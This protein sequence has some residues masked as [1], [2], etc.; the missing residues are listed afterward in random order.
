M[1]RRGRG[2]GSARE[3]GVALVE[4]ALLVPI[5]ALLSM[6][7]YEFS[8]AWQSN[9]TVQSSIRAAARTGSGLGNDRYADYSMLQALNSG[10][11]GFSAADIQQ[12]VV[13]KASDVNG[14]PTTTCKSGTATANVCN[15]YSGTQVKTL[16]QA[17]FT[18]GTTCTGTSPDINW[19]PTSRDA[20]QTTADYVGVWVR[21][22][23]KYRS[24]YFP[25]SGLTM[26][27]TMVMR[28]EPQ[29]AS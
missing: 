29:A 20:T 5:L 27:K 13:F 21:V 4:T 2:F 24:G 16:T 19:C 11:S 25:G 10:L 15:V 28:I 8:T 6:G 3:R 12:V 26:E 18:G 14:V 9:L 22:F 23:Y 7:I 1:I 17:A